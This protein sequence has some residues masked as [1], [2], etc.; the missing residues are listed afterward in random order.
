M[1]IHC[2]EELTTPEEDFWGGI[3]FSVPDY[4]APVGIGGGVYAS[5]RYYTPPTSSLRHVHIR[6]AGILHNEKGP[7][8]QVVLRDVTLEHLNISECASNGIDIIASPGYQYVHAVNITHNRGTG[9]NFVTLNG[10]TSTADRLNYIPLGPVDI[11]Y[12]IFGL[13]DIC[14]NNKAF[15]VGGKV[16]LYYKYDNRPVECIKIFTSKSR[17]SQK[18]GFRILQFNLFNSTEFTPHPDSIS[19]FDG[20][21]FNSTVKRIG[22]ISVGV[23][24][25]DNMAQT[26]FYRSQGTTLSVKL[27]AT[28]ASG[29]NGFIAEVVTIPL[30]TITARDSKHNITAS[31]FYKNRRGAVAYRSAGEITPIL[32]LHGN[33]FEDNG[34]ALFG[35]FSSSEA[36]VFFDI[37]KI[38]RAHV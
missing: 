35:N 15:P 31:Y 28:G 34:D 29:L 12:N 13:V 25:Q 26:T 38:G 37:Q 20:D 17:L 36:A 11:P 32:T 24:S 19:I 33:R 21:V 27:H 23:E 8:V 5:S 4:K 1:Y 30:Q 14:D 3:R 16:L 9:V 10:Q 7:A 22:H 18:V 6:K 2:G